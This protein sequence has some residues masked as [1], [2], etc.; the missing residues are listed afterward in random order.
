[1]KKVLLNKRVLV[2][3]D[4]E[5]VRM[6]VAHLLREMGAADVQGAGG[7][8][9]ALDLCA[10]GRVDLIISD[11]EM[12][13]LSGL[14]LLKA[15]RS[16]TSR[17]R[18]DTPVML[19]TSHSGMSIVRKAIELDAD[20]FV[21]KP[22]RPVQLEAKVEEAL[23]AVRGK[24]DFSAY[25]AIEISLKHGGGMLTVLPDTPPDDTAPGVELPR[26]AL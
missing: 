17:A 11:I 15:I 2:V 16:G 20:G 24:R 8:P 18:H 19:L 4:Q 12:E 1:M 3:D 5:M 14:H 6:V 21:V 25:A 13:P 9:A 23:G 7:V 10:R 26:E 22:V